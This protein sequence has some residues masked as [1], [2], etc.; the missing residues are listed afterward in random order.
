M[1]SNVPVTYMKRN[2][3]QAPRDKAEI[4]FGWAG[5]IEIFGE[6]E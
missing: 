2:G 6:L 4:Y 5:E 3:E 1:V